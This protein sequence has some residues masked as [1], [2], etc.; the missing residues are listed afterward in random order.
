MHQ[1][2]CEQLF[3][4]NDIGPT[5]KNSRYGDAIA[6][7]GCRKSEVATVGALAAVKILPA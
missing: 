2:L 4:G 3:T 1:T 5:F 7:A 6:N